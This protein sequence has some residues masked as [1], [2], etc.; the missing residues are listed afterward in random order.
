MAIQIG[1]TA[2]I[3]F[4]IEYITSYTIKFNDL[5]NADSKGRQPLVL[6]LSYDTAVSKLLLEN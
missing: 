4:I 1:D 2:T 5:L 6:A 3:K